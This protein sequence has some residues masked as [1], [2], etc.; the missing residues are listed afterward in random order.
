MAD[1]LAKALRGVGQTLI[2]IGLVILLFCVYELY[3]TGLETRAEQKRGRETLLE[4]WALPARAPDLTIPGSSPL[5]D[6]DVGDGLAILR[7]PRLGR[8]WAKVVFEGV[9]VSD[10]KKGPGHY[11]P[12]AQPGQIGNFVVSGHRTTYGAPFNQ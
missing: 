4:E 1:V 2:T 5:A 6:V 7:I 11:P 3:F 9:R 12:S 8:D 10:L